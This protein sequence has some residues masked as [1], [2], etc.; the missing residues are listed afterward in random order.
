MFQYARYGA[1][2]F[3]SILV[4][5][6]LAGIR[7]MCTSQR[8]PWRRCHGHLWHERADEVLESKRTLIPTYQLLLI[9]CCFFPMYR[10]IMMCVQIME[11]GYM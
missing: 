4:S 1:V 7:K 9:S 10:L 5:F 11:I 3:E 2:W 8:C 6:H